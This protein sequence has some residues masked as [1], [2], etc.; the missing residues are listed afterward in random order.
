MKKSIHYLLILLLIIPLF[1]GCEQKPQ[2]ETKIPGYSL[3]FAELGTEPMSRLSLNYS[4]ENGGSLASK[5]F[6]IGLYAS[7]TLLETATMASG[8]N[9]SRDLEPGSYKVKVQNPESYTFVTEPGEEFQ[10]V[11]GVGSVYAMVV[12]S[13][14]ASISSESTSWEVYWAETGSPAGSEKVGGGTVPPLAPG[15]FY[16]IQFNPAQNQI[17]G[18]G[19]YMFRI[20]NPSGAGGKEEAWSEAVYCIGPIQTTEVNVTLVPNPGRI[21]VSKKVSGDPP[22]GTL[23]EVVV[24]EKGEEGKEVARK[25]IRAGNSFSVQVPPGT[26]QVEETRTGGATRYTKSPAGDV[27]VGPG[28]TVNVTIN[29]V[30]PVRKGTLK[31]SK[32]VAG[33][34]PGD[35]SYTIVVKG[36]GTSV[37]KTLKAGQTISVELL[38]GTYQVTETNSGGAASN[39][40]PSGTVEVKAGQT[41]NVTVTN[42]Y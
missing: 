14:L 5:T 32:V 8:D 39:I 4:A 30:F 7:G 33:N 42:Q 41:V 21:V 11:D 12:N 23:Y 27:Q 17:G 29:N 20:L 16:N 18:K 25:S 10:L 1:S 35:Q 24:K 15:E 19:N 6:D 40:S 3:A 2:G 28:Q 31:I 26:Y 34:A 38:A 13:R 9:I 37:T 36:N 22:S